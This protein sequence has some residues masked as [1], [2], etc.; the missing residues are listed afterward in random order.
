VA[1]T[2]YHA[3]SPLGVHDLRAFD[4]TCAT[5]LVPGGAKG[6]R[7]KS[8]CP[9]SWVAAAIVGLMRDMRMRFKVSVACGKSSHHK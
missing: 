8:N 2:T 1:G 7:L 6:V 3:S 4:L 5:T 9:N